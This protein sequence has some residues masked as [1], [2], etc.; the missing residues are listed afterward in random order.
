MNAD[1]KSAQGFTVLDWLGT[2]VA[3]FSAFG[4]LL[5]PLAGRTFASMFRDVG[6]ANHLPALTRLVIS[7]WLPVILGLLV[8]SGVVAGVRA[9]TPLSRRRAFIVGA[10][11]LGG[12]GFGVCL[13]GLYLPIFAIADAVKSD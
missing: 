7:G 4:L 9:A 10:F 5:F 1:P 2:V 6:S 8:V 11:V 3:G 12:V 13:V